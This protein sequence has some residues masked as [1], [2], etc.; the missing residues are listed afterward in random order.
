MASIEQRI[1]RVERE[2]DR[3]QG[4]QTRRLSL[5]DHLLQVHKCGYA[6][7]VT[8]EAGLVALHNEL[9]AHTD[10]DRL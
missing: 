4:L 7:L 2:L 1:A 6:N 9:H 10:V 5:Y 3:Q 8:S